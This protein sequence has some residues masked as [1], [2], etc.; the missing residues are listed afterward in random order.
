MQVGRVLGS[1]F[2]HRLRLCYCTPAPRISS[3]HQLLAPTTG[4]HRDI[5]HGPRMRK[6]LGSYLLGSY[7]AVP[8]Q[9]KEKHGAVAHPAPLA[10]SSRTLCGTWKTASRMRS[11]TRTFPLLRW[12]QHPH[13][14]RGKVGPSSSCSGC[15]RHHLRRCTKGTW[16]DSP[17]ASSSESETFRR[18]GALLSE[19]DTS[20]G[21]HRSIQPRHGAV[22]QCSGKDCTSARPARQ[23]AD[24]SFHEDVR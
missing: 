9:T 10:S 12:S 5:T 21:L 8:D 15:H 7:T 24:K 20:I 13:R 22:V 16:L 19:G 11:T 18:K 3:Q 23:P 6:L 17:S 4:V 1:Q 14:K 2:H